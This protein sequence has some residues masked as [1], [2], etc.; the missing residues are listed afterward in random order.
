MFRDILRPCDD[1]GG[2]AG[3]IVRLRDD[4][5]KS[6]GSSDFMAV[7][8]SSL[9]LLLC[10]SSI[11]SYSSDLRLVLKSRTGVSPPPIG[12]GNGKNGGD[13]SRVKPNAAAPPSRRRFCAAAVKYA[14]I[15][16][17]CEGSNA[18]AAGSI[19]GICNPS[20]LALSAAFDDCRPE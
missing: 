18:A 19:D 4:T 3:E 11:S 9:E 5:D 12:D 1:G 16:A 17:D 10:G 13:E 20:G 14:A 2:S 8:S 7:S 6:N 15:A